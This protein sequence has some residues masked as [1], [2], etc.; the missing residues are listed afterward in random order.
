MT[1]MMDREWDVFAAHSLAGVALETIGT[2]TNQSDTVQGALSE[3]Q[4]EPWKCS[5]EEIYDFKPGTDTPDGTLA[6]HARRLRRRETYLKDLLDKG[7]AAKRTDNPET[8]PISSA[9]G[10]GERA[11]IQAEFAACNAVWARYNS[12][13]KSD[14]DT[15]N[16]LQA[17]TPAFEQGLKALRDSRSTE[18]EPLPAD[19]AL[20]ENIVRIRH[21]PILT[22]TQKS[23][24]VKRQ[25]EEMTKVSRQVFRNEMGSLFQ[26]EE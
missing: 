12:M 20:W 15:F 23:E 25:W 10:R 11:M 19:F 21:D 9:I 5:M 22:D 18:A 26:L 1:I 13:R 2:S 3:A 7:K 17:S 4:K 8:D 6:I 24:L 14:K 16:R